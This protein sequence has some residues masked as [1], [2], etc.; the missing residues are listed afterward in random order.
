M[1]GIA[2][3][4]STI[5]ARRK[6]GYNLPQSPPAAGSPDPQQT[7]VRGRFRTRTTLDPR[8]F[9]PRLQRPRFLRRVKAEDSA[10]VLWPTA[11]RV[12]A[13]FPKRNDRIQSAPNIALVGA[14]LPLSISR[15][16]TIG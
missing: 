1:H 12:G 7:S 4:H 6:G 15:T 13:T 2:N 10:S 9:D 5:K 8:H 11:A 16:L 3:D 14:T